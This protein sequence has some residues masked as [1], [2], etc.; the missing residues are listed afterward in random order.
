MISVPSSADLS[1]EVER[2][3]EEDEAQTGVE[4]SSEDYTLVTGGDTSTY[5]GN[6]V[7]PLSIDDL[8]GAIVSTIHGQVE[9]EDTKQVVGSARGATESFLT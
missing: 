4:L 6:L 8:H 7:D 1:E 3:D 5:H 2:G 9:E